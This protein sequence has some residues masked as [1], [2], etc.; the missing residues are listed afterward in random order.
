MASFN[1]D[2]NTRKAFIQFRDASRARRGVRLSNVSQ[3]FAERFHRLVEKLNDAVRTGG[4]LDNHTAD[5]LQNL[6]DI[7]YDKLVKVDL[8]EPR[9][10]QAEPIAEVPDVERIVTLCEF[11]DDYLTRRSDIKDSSKLVYGHVDRNLRAFFG[12]GKPISEITPGD[13]TDFGRFLK[14]D[15]LA[16]TTIDRRMS[17]TRTIFSDA[18]SH[19]M[20]ESNPFDNFRKSLRNLVSRNNRSR[21]QIIPRELILRVIAACPDEEWRCL[22]ALSRFGGLRV[23]SEALSLR[24]SDVD[25]DR[26]I[27]RVPC[28]KLEHIEGHESR[29]IPLFGELKPFLK[30]CRDKA[31]SDAEFVISRNRPP[32][33]K[34]GAGWAN[35]NLRTRLEKIIKRAG[36]TPWPRLW[37]NLRASRQTE[38]ADQFPS[39]VVCQWIGNSESVAREHYLSVTQDHVRQAVTGRPLPAVMP[40]MMPPDG[41]PGGTEQQSKDAEESKDR[42]NPHNGKKKRPHVETCGRSKV[43]DRG[44]E[45]LT[46][47]LPARR[48]PN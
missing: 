40:P 48:S 23:P 7:Y 14:R 12:E 18:V 37:H 46:F 2:K 26:D 29:E 36:L 16:P 1:Y 34:S 38:L 32:V 27:V 11:L 17:L 8:L 19:R 31:K 3:S 21:K 13:A 15:G 22:V 28:P 42:R 47:W 6:G 25:W 35:A 45:P 5:F 30:E 33:L 20:I 24:W 9:V 43:E 10:E 39:H 4:S 44:L 41:E